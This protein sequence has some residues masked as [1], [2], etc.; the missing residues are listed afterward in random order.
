MPIDITRS[1]SNERT[2]LD[3]AL[4]LYEGVQIKQMTI[5][6]TA[7]KSAAAEWRRYQAAVLLAQVRVW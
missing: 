2:V 7:Q 4:E 6:K 1:T 5:A 3:E